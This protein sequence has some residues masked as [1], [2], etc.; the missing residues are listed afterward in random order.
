MC[1]QTDYG[2]NLGLLDKNKVQRYAYG[3][4]QFTVSEGTDPSRVRIRPFFDKLKIMSVILHT[5][6]IHNKEILNLQNVNLK[7]MFNSC[8]ILQYCTITNLKISVE[9]DSTVILNIARKDN[10][11]ATVIHN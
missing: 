9:W 8:A 11:Y 10:L 3:L 2:L 4:G 6:L 5:V 1:A 7:K